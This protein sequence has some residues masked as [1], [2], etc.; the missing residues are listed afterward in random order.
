LPGLFSI[1][2]LLRS[3]NRL[4]WQMVVALCIGCALLFGLLLV[5]YARFNNIGP[6]LVAGDE[7]PAQKEDGKDQVNQIT[8][9]TRNIPVRI[10][11][12]ESNGSIAAI[13]DDSR[14]SWLQQERI[15]A[16]I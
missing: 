14:T 2:T 6:L 10:L 3:G 1:R 4:P 9:A 8:K 11:G 15:G 12:F 13:E 5:P 7:T 16:N